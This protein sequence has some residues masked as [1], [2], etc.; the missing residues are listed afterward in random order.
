MKGPDANWIHGAPA[1]RE[2]IDAALRE[3]FRD[4]IVIAEYHRRRIL[5]VSTLEPSSQSDELVI[6]HFRPAARQSLASVLK[7][8]IG[9]APALREWR[10]LGRLRSRGLHVPE[11]LGVARMGSDEWLLV[12]A[13]VEGQMLA[14]ALCDADRDAGAL[15][16]AVGSAV[17]DLH[18]TR[19]THGD[20]HIGNVFV[21]ATGPLLLDFAAAHRALPGDSVKD[22]GSLDFS[23]A[24]HG[25]PDSLRKRFRD[26]ALGESAGGL[27]RVERSAR[28]HGRRFHHSRCRRS[29]RPGRL[30]AR[31]QLG[32]LRGMRRCDFSQHSLES[33]VAAHR[34]AI[35]RGG[36]AVLKCDHRSRVS[37]TVCDGKPVIVK[38]VTKGG[39]AKALAD[40][41]RGSPARR[42]WLAGVGLLARNIHAARPLAFLERIEL[43][44]ASGSLLVLEDMRPAR[45][46]GAFLSCDSADDRGA[47]IDALCTL[48]IQLHDSQVVHGDLQ[49]HHIYL[50]READRMQAALIDLEGVRFPRT[51]SDAQRIRSLAE[52]NASLP[53]D[54]VSGEE[55]GRAFRRY[56]TA[57]PFKANALQVL[58]AIVSQSRARAHF[59]NGAD[60]DLRGKDLLSPVGR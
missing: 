44:G 14:D 23:F 42:A 48:A 33:A 10:N 27:Q 53:D 41:F 3:D 1:L 26:A 46:A 56:V 13:R 54:L 20:L 31:A 52:L 36:P 30:Y 12:L 28:A 45:P 15:L 39:V 40:R 16:A 5:V 9:L 35:A 57:L 2:R 50:R 7:Q 51:L 34:H 55:R 37:A 21:S 6:K 4:A 49:S 8:R 60:C 19:T 22:I 18:Q 24:H 29:L 59:W 17:R 47:A 11:A 38:E 32:N 25:V 43:A 58:E